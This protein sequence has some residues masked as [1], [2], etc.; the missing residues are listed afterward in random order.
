MA[1]L[2]IDIGGTNLKYAMLNHDFQI[3]KSW[4]KKTPVFLD[5]DALY[6]ELC[7]DIL[8]EDVEFIGVSSPGVVH[9]D[10]Y[11]IRSKA[12]PSIEVMVHTNIKE[13]MERRLHKPV[14]AINDGKAAAYCEVRKGSGQNT[15]SSAYWLIG[16]GIGG[17]ICRGT[18]IVTGVDG[19]AG[20]FSHIPLELSGGK[21]LWVGDLAAIHA[22]EMLYNKNMREEEWIDNPKEICRRYLAGEKQAE[23]AMNEW[24]WHNVQ[25]MYMIASLY[26][27]EVICIGGAISREKWLIDKMRERFYELDYRFADI[28]TTRIE[29][30]RYGNDANIIG[31]VMYAEEVLKKEQ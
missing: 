1:Y 22:L 16:T 26:N 30:C 3:Q 23:K 2:G 28:L 4:K 19:I 11:E 31:A 21:V 20:E 10:T 7:R 12:S 27:P 29:Q 15:R 17:C 13:E 18:E 14:V 24:I 5:K 9:P 25:G 8:M 6:D